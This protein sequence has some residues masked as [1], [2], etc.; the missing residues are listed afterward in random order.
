MGKRI[1]VLGGGTAGTMVANRLARRMMNSIRSGDLEILLITHSK[2]HMYQPGFLSVVFNEKFPEQIVREEKS[3]VHRG[4]TLIFDEIKKIRPERNCV[5]SRTTEYPYDYLVIATGSCP[6]FDSVPGLRESA[7]HFY[8]LDDALRLRDRLAAMEKGRVLI[9]VDDP[10]KGPAA[11]IEF[12][13]MLDDYLGRRGIREEVRLTY[14][15]SA[16][17]IHSLEPVADWVLS[18]F[19]R[20]GIVQEPLFRLEKVDPLRKRA[21][22]SDGEEHPFDV[23]IAVPAHRG[24]PVILQSG[25]GDERGFIPTDRRTLKMEGNDRVYVIGDAAN[26][27]IPKGGSAYYQSEILVQNLIS[28]LKGLPEISFYDGKGAFFLGNSL[29]DAGFIAYDYDHFPESVS[30]SG[31]LRWFKGMQ[32][33]IYWL[34][35][36]AIL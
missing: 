20:R 1:V 18:Q 24:A 28:R 11:P 3:L 17:R 32:E 21:F 29:Q 8:T 15:F 12:T 23:L 16:G 31:V 19:E 10:H 34:N 27:P 36:R 30:S 25:I 13:L 9:T 26:L 33:S 5:Q 35:V 22:T 14:A 6:D 4:V 2:K 7:C